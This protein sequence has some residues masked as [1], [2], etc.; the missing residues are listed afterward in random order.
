MLLQLLLFAVGHHLNHMA[1]NSALSFIPNIVIILK[2]RFSRSFLFNPEIIHGISIFFN[3][4]A[5]FI[6]L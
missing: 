2:A 1:C 6:K 5:R 3:T 4:D